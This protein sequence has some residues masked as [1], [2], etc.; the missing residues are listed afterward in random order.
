MSCIKDDYCWDSADF[1]EEYADYRPCDDVVTIDEFEEI[2]EENE[3]CLWNYPLTE[4]DHIIENNIDVV[5]VRFTDDYD[6][7]EYRFCEIPKEDD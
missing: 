1:L 2:L 3:I 6:G 5:L 4:I 7:Y